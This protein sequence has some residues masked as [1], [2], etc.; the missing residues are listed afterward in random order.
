MD[1]TAKTVLGSAILF[2]MAFIATMSALATVSVSDSLGENPIAR[3]TIRLDGETFTVDGSSGA[4][5]G[6]YTIP[7]KFPDGLIAVH[8]AV[9]DLRLSITDVAA[10]SGID[11]SV[12]TVAQNDSDLGDTGEANII[13]AIG[14]DPFTNS[15]SYIQGS[16][17]AQTVVDGTAGAPTLYLHLLVDD[18]DIAAVETNTLSGTITIL[19]SEVADY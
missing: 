3:T 15:T 10:G 14:V 16:I 12:G 9:A 11:V 1:S 5:E 17:S 2:A 8:G 7:W 19:W 18:A 4:G 6:S 13:G